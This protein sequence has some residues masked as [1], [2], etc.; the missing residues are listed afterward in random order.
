MP[1][2]PREMKFDGVNPPHPQIYFIYSAQTSGAIRALLTR[3][4]KFDGVNAFTFVST[5]MRCAKEF[6]RMAIKTESLKNIKN[7]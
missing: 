6:N 5:I 2:L 4:M 1:P 3:E 7:L